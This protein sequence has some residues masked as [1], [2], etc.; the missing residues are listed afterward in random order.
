MKRESG[1][2][3]LEVIFVLTAITII[4]A[5]VLPDL[6]EFYRWQKRKENEKQVEKIR[7]AI[8][9]IYDMYAYDVD[10]YDGQ[11]FRFGSN[12]I[13]SGTTGTSFYSVS[14]YAGMSQKA[15]GRDV[16]NMEYTAYVSNRLASTTS[17]QVQY[18]VIAFVSK[19][20][21]SKLSSLFDASEG[22]LTCGSD[23]ICAE[24]S[25]LEIQVSKYKETLKKMDDTGNTFQSYF[26]TLYLADPNHDVNVDRFAKTDRNGASVPTKWDTNSHLLN[27]CTVADDC[28]ATLNDINAISTLKFNPEQIK[29]AWGNEFRVD[30]GS[31]STRNPDNGETSPYSIRILTTTPWGETIVKTVFGV[32]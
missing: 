5:F 8:E 14:S 24:V 6:S 4:F 19:S 26:T 2:T 30:N 16:Y 13:T 12:T 21:D 7:S 31:S 29:D 23:D 20:T 3:A 15:V 32:Y 1:F 17:P 28:I 11:E 10:S 9:R 27:S 25:G 18:H 22:K